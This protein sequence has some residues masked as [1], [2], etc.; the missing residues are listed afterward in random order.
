MQINETAVLTPYLLPVYRKKMMYPAFLILPGGGYVFTSL[1]EGP[2]IAQQLNALGYQAFVLDYSCF[3]RDPTF[4]LQKVL[5]EVKK[6]LEYIIENAN[7]LRVDPERIN[8]IGFSAGGHLAAIAGSL[9]YKYIKRVVLGYP[10][11]T[12]KYVKQEVADELLDQTAGKDASSLRMI[13]SVD[14]VDYVSKYTPPTFIWSTAEDETVDQQGIFDYL[15]Q[16]YLAKVP[17][18]FHLYEKGPHGLSLA[19]E[20]TAESAAYVVPHAATWVKLLSGW[21][22]DHQIE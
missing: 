7:V 9:F 15:R 13:W 1:R 10:A 16:L 21:L 11:L 8:I 2:P 5:D 6:S 17:V 12:S 4:N 18:E 20:A 22:A 19:N 3:E 14:A